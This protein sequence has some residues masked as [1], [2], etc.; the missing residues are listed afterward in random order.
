MKSSSTVLRVGIVG[1]GGMGQGHCKRVVE[2][3]PEMKLAAVCDA[4]APTAEKV[5]AELKVPHFTA[6]RD[7]IAANCC[8]AV[9]V[10][11]PH[12][13]HP[14][15]SI[16]C[17]EA[18]LHVLTEKPVSERIGTAEEMVKT[19]E[20][21]GVTLGVIF[22]QR[23]AGPHRKAIEL[24]KSGVLG[25]VHR[26]T[27]LIP[28]YRTQ[29]YYNAGGWRATWAG[30]GGGVLLNQSPHMVDLLVQLVGLPK[31]V[32]GRTQTFMHDI[33][34]EDL[35][36][37]LLAFPGGG[38]GYLYASTI[39]PQSGTGVQFAI[40]GENG[41]LLLADGAVR[42]FKYPKGVAAFTRETTEMWAKFG[43][44]EVPL[45]YKKEWPAHE[46][47]MQNFARHILF[48]EELL[49]SAR[50]GLGQLE[51]ANAVLLSSW[52]G[53][54]LELPIDRALY[55]KL[56]NERCAKSRWH[57]KKSTEDIRLTDPSFV[58]K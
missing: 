11:T 5:G 15:I 56:M 48:G 34:V 20:R 26:V 57:T 54:E 12:P 10:A 8:D 3:V 45:D 25:P 21:K 28:D 36:D 50:S 22:Q 16:A 4:H 13:L 24:M 23:F 42:L 58:K 52:L 29:A 55:E 47:P 44:E 18:G 2:K 35:A 53:K 39:E 38:I 6:Y 31:T 37:A 30:E 49:C 51:L 32:R 14:E 33:E 46:A 1:L 40:A 17:M 27:A 7:M 41:K 9:I 43:A 19:A